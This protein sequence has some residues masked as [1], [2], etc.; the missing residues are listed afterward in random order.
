MHIHSTQNI[1]SHLTKAVFNIIPRLSTLPLLLLGPLLSLRHRLNFILLEVTLGGVHLHFLLLGSFSG[2]SL[3]FFLEQSI[4]LFLC[5][6]VREL[7]SILLHL[8]LVLFPFLISLL[9]I[10][11][12]LLVRKLIPNLSCHPSQFGYSI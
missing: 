2:P 10:W 11:L 6:L 7:D 3:F 9:N 4:L 1:N 12:L 5:N 8:F